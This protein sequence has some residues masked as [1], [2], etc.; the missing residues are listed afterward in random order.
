M[1]KPRD[2]DYVRMYG[3]LR[4]VEEIDVLEHDGDP[5]ALN[6][7]DDTRWAMLAAEEDACMVY[8]EPEEA[9]G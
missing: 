4:R 6:D 7:E 1:T 2:W 3:A 9:R 8:I 5:V